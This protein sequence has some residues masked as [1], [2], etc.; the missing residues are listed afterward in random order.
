MK[1]YLAGPMRGKPEFNFPAF[2]DAARQLRSLGHEVFSPAEADERRHGA[3]FATGTTGDHKEIESKG[4]DLG[5]AL[6]EDLSWICEEAD[7]IAMLPEWETSKGATAEF[8][9][10]V[11]LGLEVM[12]VSKAI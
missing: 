5:T 8:F 10:A 1:I 7:G 6:A 11:A 9:T 2:R 4:F 12:F 3:D